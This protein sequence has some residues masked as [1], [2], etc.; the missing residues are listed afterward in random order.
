MAYLQIIMMFNDISTKLSCREKRVPATDERRRM[1]CNS[2]YRTI[3]QLYCSDN[4][5]KSSY[6]DAEL[7]Q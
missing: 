5:P 6:D 7:Q 1:P 3:W 2:P 4:R